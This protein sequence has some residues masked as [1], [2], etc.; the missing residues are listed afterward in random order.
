MSAQAHIR[1]M[2]GIALFL[3]VLFSIQLYTVYKLE[4]IENRSNIRTLPILS[5]VSLAHEREMRGKEP[6]L[7]I[8]ELMAKVQYVDADGASHATM[9]QL[10][11]TRQTMLALRNE[12]HQ[13]NVRL[14]DS[15]VALLQELTDEQWAFVQ[16]QRDQIQAA[17]ELKEMNRLLER[18]SQ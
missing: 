4:F 18:W 15:G 1:L 5:P 7:N 13:L 16:S 6:P 2:K 17:T 12:R 3:G 11:E 14:M 8:H 10:V 9:K